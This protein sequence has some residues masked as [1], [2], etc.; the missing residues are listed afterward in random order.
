MRSNKTTIVRYHC[1]IF[2]TSLSAFYDIYQFKHLYWIA[3][4]ICAGLAS[5]TEKLL[6]SVQANA[7][8]EMHAREWQEKEFIQ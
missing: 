8:C 5:L 6:T 4:F 7:A 2:V 1:Y 3:Y